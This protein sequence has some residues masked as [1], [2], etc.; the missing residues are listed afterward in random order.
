MVFG[1]A[2]GWQQQR[3]QLRLALAGR[4]VDSVHAG[5]WPQ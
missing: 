5:S 3:V 4:L 1:L 2:W